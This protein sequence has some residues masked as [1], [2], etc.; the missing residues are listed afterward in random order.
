MIIAFIAFVVFGSMSLDASRRSWKAVYEQG[1]I[2][3]KE[4][5]ENRFKIF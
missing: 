2:D 5:Y 1:I 4:Y 3:A